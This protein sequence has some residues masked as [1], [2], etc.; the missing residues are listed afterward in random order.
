[1]SSS[2][3]PQGG[4][5]SVF[6]IDAYN[7]LYRAYHAM[8]PLSAPDGT[9]VN[10]VHGFVRMVQQLRKDLKPEYMLAVFDSSGPSFRSE[11]FPAYKAQRPP[12]PEDMVPQFDLVRRAVDALG[13]PRVE[14]PKIEADDLI[15][16]YALAAHAAGKT[17]T[18]VSSDKDLMQLVR[19]PTESS[20][21]IAIYDTMK[22]KMI[23]PEAVVAK[24][25]V[26]P[27]LLGD[28]LAL[29]G[30][31]SDNIP[32]VQ[33]IGAKTA[34]ALLAEYGDLEGVLKAAPGIKQKKR[35]E[36]LI[37]HAEDARMSRVLVALKTDVELPLPLDEIRDPGPDADV[38]TAFFAPLGFR[39]L[40]GAA[41]VARAVAEIRATGGGGT[42]GA[43]ELQP[44]TK[45]LSLD[46]STFRALLAENEAELVEL[47]AKLKECDAVAVQC[48]VDHSDAL[49]ANLVGIAL[50]GVGEGAPGPVYIPL[51]HEGDAMLQ[52][53]IA[54]GR[55]HELLRPLLRGDSPAKIVHAHKFQGMVLSRH[56]LP[57]AGVTMDPQLCSYT[58]DP[59]RSSHTLGI[60]AAELMGY[61]VES[62]EKVLG[63]GKKA[64]TFDRVELGRATRYACERVAVVAAVGAHLWGEVER[65]GDAARKLFVE[66]EM[67]LAGVLQ[68]LEE[69]G[70][71]VDPAVLDAQSKGLAAEIAKLQAEI[72]VHAGH[73]INPDSPTQL[74]KLLF[75]ELGLPATRKTKTG[76]S[77]DAQ[78]LEE[79]SLYHPVVNQILEYRSLTKLKGTYLDTLPRAINPNT[80]RLH[81]SFRQAVAQTGRLSSKDPNL[82]NIPIRTE[83]GR[84]IRDAF[85]APAGTMLVTLDYSQ[86]ELRV[87]AHLSKDK[88]LV[89]AFSDGVD[90]HR[91]TAAEVFD[92]PEDE[93]TGEQRRVAKAVNFGVIYGQTAF[94]LGRQLGI[95]RGKAGSY[96][97]AYLAKL[98]G[99]TNYMS[100]LVEEAK[101]LGYAET[102]FGRKRRI[103]ELK[104]KGA[105]RAYGERIARNTPIQ[106][107]A[108]DILKRAMIDVDRAIQ[109]MDYASMLL[110]VHDE[111]I[112]QCAIGRVDELI[113]LV[114]PLMEG[115]V[116]L[117][118]PLK[119]DVGQGASW[120]ACKG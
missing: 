70:I 105:A 2:A 99:V 88:N 12:A 49:L 77:T 8:P 118:V 111:L 19:E 116:E 72:E 76:Y 37:E 63:K 66:L 90:V 62:K 42:V 60:L 32:G 71:A 119:V 38:M 31:S 4:P 23:G 92:V 56:G 93:V 73:P 3:Q 80:G 86:I 55:A 21:A 114:K 25:G 28:L 13:I 6:L 34:A 83:V 104:R 35:R 107:S 89:S 95:P 84:K 103:P 43:H 65:A 74:Q 36:R 97:K 30:D 59:A 16:T 52:K 53:P 17:V 14:A 113:G 22:R 78:V 15:A 69:R 100:A 87:L 54:E 11:L 85:V 68:R 41:A 46:P 45:P 39:S 51:R 40:V 106:G 112:F 5:G 27:E 82:Q 47:L 26:T 57:L 117:S 20:P 98:P 67:P 94:G 75:D 9:P 79:L 109:G 44:A 18:I 50:A 48:A 108:A 110:T 1:M 7:F 24:F 61:A 91:R 33:G 64:V 102:I 29:M 96:I 115:A 120:G 58:L 81:T 101:R 10:A